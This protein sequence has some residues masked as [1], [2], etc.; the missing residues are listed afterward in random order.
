MS[1]RREKRKGKGEPLHGAETESEIESEKSLRQETCWKE[2]R[3]K[4]LLR[5]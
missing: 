5:R 3:V 4:R 1:L 2:E